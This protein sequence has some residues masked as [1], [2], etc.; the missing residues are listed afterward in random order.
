MTALLMAHLNISKNSL[1]VMIILLFYKQKNGGSAKA[2]NIGLKHATGRYI[3]FLDADDLLDSNY[4]EEQ[5]KFIEKNGPIITAGYRRI[6]KESNTTF[7]PR[8]SISYKGL[9]V[10]ND[11]S[12]L[13]TM[14]D[15]N[16]IG[17]VYF[18][19]DIEK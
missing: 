16:V 18:P 14:Y 19:E 15:R 6:H 9:L 5:L 12:C 8:K 1:K 7:M 10:G 2:R 13:T 3:T 4:L 11:A 17:D